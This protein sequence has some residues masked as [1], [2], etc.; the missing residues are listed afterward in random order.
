MPTLP[1][2]Q[3]VAYM[4]AHEDDTLVPNIIACTSICGAASI[5]LVALRFYSHWLTSS[6]KIARLTDWLMVAAWVFFALFDVAFALTTRYGGGRHIIVAENPRLLQILNILN[7]NTYLYAMAFIKFSILSLYGSIFRSKRFHFC[8]WTIAIVVGAWAVSLSLVA[9][10]QCTPIAYGWDPTVAGG[11]CLNYGLAVL[12]AGVVNI[13]TDFTILL[14]PI[15]LVRRLHVSSQKKRL[16]IFTFAF[17]GSAYVVSIIR[18]AFAL[19][20]GT[21]ADG[22]WDN[23]PAGLLSVVELL[24]G[25]LAASIPRYR[26]LWRQITHGSSDTRKDSMSVVSMGAS[27]ARKNHGIEQPSISAM[28]GNFSL[29]SAQGI[30]VTKQIE[31]VAYPSKGRSWVRV[32]DDEQPD[33]WHAR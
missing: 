12:I 16:L 9:I 31:M 23:I 21:T 30:N 13:I 4:L 22:S 32:P 17:G 2:A 33:S 5:V 26:V 19:K 27:N 29:E 14:M 6:P 10:F 18:L 3:E 11:S 24:I 1:T 28:A 20:V 25:I 7:E 8:L 15:P